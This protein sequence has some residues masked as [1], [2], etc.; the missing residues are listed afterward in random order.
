MFI[1][2]FFS[3]GKRTYLS[4]KEQRLHDWSTIRDDMYEA[5]ISTEAPSTV[6]CHEC[7]KEAQ[8]FKC[9]DCTPWEMVCEDCLYR[10]HQYPHLH[11]FEAWRVSNTYC[12]NFF[13][14]EIMFVQ[15]KEI[16]NILFYWTWRCPHFYLLFLNLKWV[17]YCHGHVTLPN[18]KTLINIFILIIGEWI[19]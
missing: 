2:L 18:V 4:L 11:M 5:F 1:C 14:Y 19:H 6:S 15:F 10:R 7:N 13:F 3:T 9:I 8:L 17:Y 12:L 16:W